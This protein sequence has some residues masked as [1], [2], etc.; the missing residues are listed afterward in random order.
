DPGQQAVLLDRVGLGLDPDRDHAQRQGCFGGSPAEG[1]DVGDVLRQFGG[2]QGVADLGRPLGG[3]ASPSGVG[4][5]G[6]GV[7]VVS[8]TAGGEGHG[9]GRGHEYTSKHER[10][11]MVRR[12]G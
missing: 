9:K 4:G 12:Y 11:P 3:G 1:D 5:G 6:V 10:L 8:G 2:A 7:G